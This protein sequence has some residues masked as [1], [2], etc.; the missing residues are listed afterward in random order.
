MNFYP[1]DAN[2]FYYK[3]LIYITKRNTLIIMYYA[4]QD[5]AQS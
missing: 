5:F 2:D 1:F 4:E 3:P